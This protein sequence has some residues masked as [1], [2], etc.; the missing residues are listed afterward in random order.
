[1]YEH[2]E[3]M[4]EVDSSPAPPEAFT[5]IV[6]G[7]GTV[8]ERDMPFVN[9]EEELW[10]L[11]EVNAWNLKWL[12]ECTKQPT[13]YREARLL[14]CIQYF[15]A[16]KTTLGEQF[17]TQLKK[18]VLDKR[19]KKREGLEEE[20]NAVRQAGIEH[21]LVDV[22][23]EQDIPLK[24]LRVLLKDKSLS[25]YRSFEDA[26]HALV[27]AVVL[28]AHAILLHFDE[29]GSH[30]DHNLLSLQMFVV[31]VLGAMWEVKNRGNDL[32]MIFFLVTGKNTDFFFPLE[33][34]DVANL[35]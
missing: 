1:M 28:R 11:F 13:N 29:V 15:G 16:G 23:A 35:L 3:D 24:A 4:E 12:R 34:W 6:R 8:R 7:I 17:G 27:N 22:R 26:A 19:D 14:Y 30:P 20:W 10:R 18:G 9:R 5:F 25:P 33:L 2:S 31:A 32:P 21:I